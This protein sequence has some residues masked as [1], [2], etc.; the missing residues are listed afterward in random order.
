MTYGMLDIIKTVLRFVAF[1]YVC[2]DEYD[3][4]AEGY[5]VY[6]QY[7]AIQHFASAALH[8]LSTQVPCRLVYFHFCLIL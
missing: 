4:V 7:R 6:S 5:L 3:S 2:C 1:F 8:V